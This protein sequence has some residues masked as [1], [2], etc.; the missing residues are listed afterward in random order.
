MYEETPNEI[1]IIILGSVG[2]GKTCLITRYKTGKFLQHIPSTFGSNFVKIDKIINNKKYVLNIWDTAGQEKYNSLTQTF[3]KNAKIVILVYSIIDKKSFLDLDNWLKLVKEGNGE[4]GY[5]LGVAANKWDLYLQSEVSDKKGKEYAKKINAI[6]KSTSAKE[7]SKGIEEL[8]SELT[9]EYI[10]IEESGG[11][12]RTE[13]I[14][15]DKNMASKD[16]KGGCCGGG[17]KKEK[18]KITTE[19]KGSVVS[20][21][22]EDK[23]EEEDED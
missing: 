22:D 12:I 7:E 2:V 18:N 14:R 11:N 19:N 5:V 21:D 4:K 8:I 3:T 15:L 17:K 9:M 6:W 20:K 13:S 16:K 1:K 10:K 23:E